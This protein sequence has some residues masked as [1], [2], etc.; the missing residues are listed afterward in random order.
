MPCAIVLVPRGVRNWHETDMAMQ[1]QHVRC[2]GLNGPSSDA[3]R[4]LKMTDF[5]AKVFLGCRTKILRATGAFC[6]RRCE[7]TYRL[8]QNRS[9]TS[10][11]ALKSDAAAERSKDQLPRDF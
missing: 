9:R 4:R 8:I 2:A 3:A 6:A 1:S 11:M 10:V 5:V 7:G